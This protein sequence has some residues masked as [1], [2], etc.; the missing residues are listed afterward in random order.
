MIAS[1][2]AVRLDRPSLLRA[3]LLRANLFGHVRRISLNPQSRRSSQIANVQLVRQ[4]TPVT[5]VPHLHHVMRA[6]LRRWGVAFA[7]YVP[8]VRMPWPAVRVALL[9]RAVPFLAQAQHLCKTVLCGAHAQWAK[10]S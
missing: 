5:V 9:A 10:V 2:R 8:L 1:V 4:V 3:V 6:T 7:G